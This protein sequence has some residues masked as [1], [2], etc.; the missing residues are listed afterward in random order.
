MTAAA[1]AAE[2]KLDPRQHGLAAPQQRNMPPDAAFGGL[3]IAVQVGLSRGTANEACRFN[4][5]RAADC[6]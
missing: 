3:Q 2:I 4:Q 6:V 5:Y 1:G